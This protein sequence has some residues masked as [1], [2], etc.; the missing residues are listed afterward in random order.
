MAVTL[1]W[2]THVDVDLQ[3]SEFFN[4]D[5]TVMVRFM[6]QYPNAYFGPLLAENGSG[7]YR[8][9]QGDFN[10]PP[11]GTCLFMHIGDQALQIY[12]TQTR[13]LPLT[14]QHMA[15]VRQANQFTLY[16]NGDPLSPSLQMPSS[17]VPAGTVRL[18]K[19]SPG[20]RIN[21]QDAQFYGIVDE[22]A[23]YTRPLTQVEIQSTVMGLPL[24]GGEPGLLTWWSFDPWYRLD[25]YS[26]ARPGRGRKYWLIGPARLAQMSYNRD[27]RLDAEL[28]PAPINRQP[29]YL[30]FS[31]GVE[32]EVIQGYDEFRGTHTGYASFCW[33]FKIAGEPQ[34]TPYPSGSRGAPFLACAPGKV[35]ALREST[36]PPPPVTNPADN[37]QRN[38]LV[39]EQAPQ[40]LCG[41]LHLLKDSSQV[42][43]GRSVVRHQYLANTGGD[44]GTET[45]PHLH[46]GVSNYIEPAPN[47]V[48][49]P[50]AFRNY[51][52]RQ[53]DFGWKLIRQGIPR[54]H[55]VIRRRAAVASFGP[56]ETWDNSSVPYF[57]SRGTSFADLDG[58]GKADWILV[59]DDCLWVRRSSGVGFGPMEQWTLEPFFGSRGTFFAD[60]DGD[61]KADAIAVND[62][63]ITVRR[64]TGSAFGIYEKWTREP[65]YGSRGT[66]FADVDGDGKADAIVVNDDGITVRR[67][68]G[69]DFGGYEK[70]T[71]EPYYGSILTSFADVDGD[72]K[73][74]AIVVN[75]DRITV[76]RSTGAAFGAYESWTNEPF[77]PWSA[78]VHNSLWPAM[79]FVDV[80]GDGKAD[81]IVANLMSADPVFVRR[82]TGLAFGQVEVWGSAV[83]GSACFLADVDGDGMADLIELHQSWPV[84]LV[85]RAYPGVEP[86]KRLCSDEQLFQMYSQF[87][88]SFLSRHFAL[89]KYFRGNH[90]T[91]DNTL[92]T[93]LDANAILALP[94]PEQATHR[95]SREQFDENPLY[96]GGHFM[97]C[98]AVEAALGHPHAERIL[99]SWLFTLRSLYKF[100]GNHFDGYPLRWDPAT[101]DD[102][103]LDANGPWYSRQFLRDSVT[104]SYLFSPPHSDPRH[105]PYRNHAGEDGH[106]DGDTWIPPSPSEWLEKTMGREEARRYLDRQREFFARYRRWE[107]SMDELVGLLTGYFMLHKHSQNGGNRF[108]ASRQVN[109][110]GDFLAEHSYLLV[111]PN[112]GLTGRGANGVTLE[113]VFVQAMRAITG[114]DY[115]ARSNFQQVME[116]A[117]CW[118]N[119]AGPLARWTVLGVAASP[120]VEGIT[121]FVKFLGAERLLSFSKG[122]VDLP[123][124]PRWLRTK[125][126]DLFQKLL[127]TNSI[128][129]ARSAAIYIHRECFDVVND[130]EAGSVALAFMLMEYFTPQERFRLWMYGMSFMGAKTGAHAQ[131]FPMC[132]GLMGL[133]GD[134]MVGQVYLDW[135]YE[136]QRHPDL[137]PDDHTRAFGCFASAVALLHSESPED[138]AELTKRL[139]SRYDELSLFGGDL[140]LVDKDG[141][142]RELHKRELDF[143]SGLALAWLYRMRRETAG[144]AVSAD[145][146]ALPRNIAFWPV[147]AV[148]ESVIEA[149]LQ[150]RLALPVN[151]IQK[152]PP[153]RLQFGAYGAP[154]FLEDDPPHKPDVAAP[155]LAPEPIALVYDKTIAVRESDHDVYTGIVL[156]DGDIYFF[157]AS[158]SIWADI[159][160]AGQNGPNG[161]DTITWDAR[162]PLHGGL[163]RNNA[164]PYSLLGRHFGGYFFIGEGG[165]RMRYV[166]DQDAAL[167]LRINDDAPGNGS[168]SFQV[169]IRV[170]GEPRRQPV[171]QAIEFYKAPTAKWRVYD[172]TGNVDSARIAGTPAVLPGDHV[173]IYAHG[174]NHRLLEFYKTPADP[175][176]VF[177]LSASV[178]GFEIA[179]DPSV[180]LTGVD[181]HVYARGA[182]HQLLEFYKAPTADWQLINLSA[183]AG[184]IAVVGDPVALLTGPDAH[185][186]VR[187]A[188]NHLLEFYKAPH[189]AQWQVID[190]SA[191]TGGTPIVGDPAVL[192]AAENVHVYARG[193]NNQLLEFCKAPNPARWTVDDLSHVVGGIGIAGDPAALLTGNDIHVYVRSSDNQLIEFYKAPSASW[194]MINLSVEAGG[195]AIKGDPAVLLTD[196]DLHLYARGVDGRLLEFYKAPHPAQWQVFDL[197]TDAGSASVTLDPA[198][199]LTGNDVHVYAGGDPPPPR[200]M[201]L[202]V[203]P[204][205]TPVRR[206]IALTVNATDALD[207]TPVSGQVRLVNFSANGPSAVPVD[208]LF[209]AGAVH[210]VTLRV[211]IEREFDPQTG[212]WL[213][214]PNYPHG[215]VEAVG[216]Q[217]AEIP[218]NF[219]R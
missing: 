184:R 59:R 186:Y 43:Q 61:G 51:E 214:T 219:G 168:G 152:L 113:Y 172:L 215:V 8:I 138:E 166:F 112:G 108:E 34:N 170:W 144:K 145:F 191:E 171:G 9:G 118:E 40:E 46:L 137:E 87:R 111:R 80:D 94:T 146:P 45:F 195:R 217:D 96:T 178:G 4:A 203:Q 136:R 110:L 21:G 104:G 163:D 10:I 38:Y 201:L 37:D 174:A 14:W 205:P 71:D 124:L 175:W 213:E 218:F 157:E 20:Q 36:P 158:G 3:F 68:T 19:T 16:W 57:G 41:Y 194:Q 179:G 133:D 210:R 130:G 162:F 50:V 26:D 160:A 31:E 189:P 132:L 169:R 187:G 69:V 29:M 102:W 23:V 49:Y 27:H 197:S 185:L 25:P 119:L 147:P 90:F 55:D 28:I 105:A 199:I 125:G 11:Q 121:E 52:V 62:D 73:A 98:I 6:P 107:P 66:F 176:Q 101:S 75:S 143:M 134:P 129:M 117:G 106:W 139:C 54:L 67:S 74:D 182:G 192:L 211:G 135:Y 15:V 116:Q 206:R 65:Y 196:Y 181:V 114:N 18:G 156:Q 141:M 193:V 13:I 167:W 109:R 88:A 78:S 150:D 115:A 200:Q 81:A 155:P 122:L 12:K 97:A 198:V 99:R 127:D 53:P 149:A 216:Y 123:G 190:P 161:R 204:T 39:V 89:S 95:W 58:D 151:A 79:F 2:Q 140:S 100:Q 35:V 30:P 103:E 48:T 83:S 92:R 63:G 188:G 1:G 153:D 164:H 177:D 126:S 128:Q 120:V 60:V 82:S 17:G 33:D 22:L 208:E 91:L 207:N 70:W 180:L 209:D 212:I 93:N 72:G 142:V 165:R 44:G 84:I 64:S 5:H 47:F 159:A 173:H 85:R 76:R 7:I 202:S 77:Y 131:G 86:E 32:W 154:L 148:P 24:T 183:E 56:A 42:G